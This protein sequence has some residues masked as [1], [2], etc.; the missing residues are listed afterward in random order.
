M[1]IHIR[2]SRYID[3]DKAHLIMLTF[4]CI[5]GYGIFIDAV[6]KPTADYNNNNNINSPL[7]LF[8]VT[9]D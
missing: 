9:L 4:D 3:C 5:T 1:H 6:W 7:C 2:R 8:P